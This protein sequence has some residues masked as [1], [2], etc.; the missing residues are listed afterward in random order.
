MST[1]AGLLATLL[2]LY[3]LVLIGR[4]IFDW[5][6]VFSRNWQPTGVLLVI[7]EAIYTVTDPPL[8]VLRKLIPP[9]RIGQVAL[10]L[11]FLILILAIGIVVSL[12]S[13]FA[14]MG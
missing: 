4:L 10:D 12:L 9:L 8:R 14:A 2:W 11:S 7:A 3:M 13:T 5:V 1:I 6:Q